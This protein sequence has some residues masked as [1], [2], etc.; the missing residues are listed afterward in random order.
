M[1]EYK[2]IVTKVVDGDTLQ[3]SV[4]VGFRLRIDERFRI[5]GINAPDRGEEGYKESKEFLE[6]LILNKEVIVKTYKADGFRRWLAYVEFDDG[7][8][9]LDVGS[10][11]LV[12]GLA[13]AYK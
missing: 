11:M 10:L 7:N 9:I 1:Y 13:T 8:E 4:D 2:G 6:E 3:I 12:R 5:L